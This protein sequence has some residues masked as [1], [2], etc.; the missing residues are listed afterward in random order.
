MLTLVVDL[1]C[2]KLLPDFRSAIGIAPDCQRLIGSARIGLDTSVSRQK[3]CGSSLCCHTVDGGGF[4]NHPTS[5]CRRRGR[6]AGCKEARLATAPTPVWTG[7]AS[8]LV[9]P[10]SSPSVNQGVHGSNRRCPG[11]LS[12]PRP[13]YCRDRRGRREILCKPATRPAGRVATR[14]FP[15]KTVLR[16]FEVLLGTVV[17]TIPD[18]SGMVA[19][20]ARRRDSL[21]T[22]SGSTGLIRGR[23]SEAGGSIFVCP[24][25]SRSIS[26]AGV[27]GRQ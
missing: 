14:G 6:L 10:E 22:A 25:I 3:V 16:L 24:R 13:A 8:R 23:L 20:F 12:D 27:S 19:I 18:R 15:Q 17:P 5:R 7:E 26:A 1:A 21:S 2:Q 11:W 4:R 9:D